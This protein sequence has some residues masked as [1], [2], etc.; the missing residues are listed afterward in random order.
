MWAVVSGVVQILFLI[1]KNM[2]EK[3]AELRKKREELRGESQEAI[4]SGDASRINIVIGK[5]RQR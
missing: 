5:L 1:L 4:K 2:F 3:D